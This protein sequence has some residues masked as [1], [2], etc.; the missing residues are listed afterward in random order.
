MRVLSAAFA[1][2]VCV[3][4]VLMYCLVALAPGA[5]CLKVLM[6]VGVFAVYA[7]MYRGWSLY[8]YRAL[9][10]LERSRDELDHIIEATPS[11]VVATPIARD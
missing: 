10:A 5:I 7:A 3:H 1:T 8:A 6:I 4:W 11:G 9:A 2:I